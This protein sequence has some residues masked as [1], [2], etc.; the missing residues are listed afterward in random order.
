MTCMGTPERVADVVSIEDKLSESV[1]DLD[2]WLHQGMTIRS[3]IALQLHALRASR[4]T[5]VLLA[6]EELDTMEAS[7]SDGYADAGSV[8]D[9]RKLV[10]AS[11]A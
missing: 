2:R 1:A 8:A 7:G 10:A 11:R 3:T 9:L 5:Q 6:V 4:S